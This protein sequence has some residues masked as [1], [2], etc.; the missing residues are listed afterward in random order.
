MT[1]VEFTTPSGEALPDITAA[2]YVAEHRTI[3]ACGSDRFIQQL[4][5]QIEELRLGQGVQ[6]QQIEGLQQQIDELRLDRSQVV[7]DQQTYR[8]IL[9]RDI[10]VRARDLLSQEGGQPPNTNFYRFSTQ[11]TPGFLEEWNLTEDTIIFLNGSTIRDGD[12][13][14]HRLPLSEL[15]RGL[16]GLTGDDRRN[17]RLLCNF[18]SQRALQQ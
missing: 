9:R 1:E 6:R 3:Y 10:A 7:D 18:V 8:K 14:A 17:M 12:E 5:Q 15:Q 4:Q 16:E 11:L 2:E 13:V